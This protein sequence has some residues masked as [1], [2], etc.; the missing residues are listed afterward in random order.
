MND[1]QA[2]TVPTSSGAR[3]VARR[4]TGVPAADGAGVRLTRVIGAPEL[5]MLDP[6]LLLDVFESD[7]PDDYI[8]GFPPHPHRGF[9]TVT[10]MLAGR[11]EHRDSTGHQGVIETGGV[12]WMTAGRGIIHS[13]MPKQSD[14]LL[15]GIQ[16]WVNL[17]ARLKMTD[18]DYREFGAAAIPADTSAR[19]V[20]TRV[21]AGT[22]PGGLTG[23][24]TDV[25]TEP[26]F[27][28]ITTE[29]G[30]A[31]ELPVPEVHAVMI[32]VVHGAIRIGGG[33][34]LVDA[35]SLAVLGDGERVALA[36]GAAGGRAL[37]FAARPLQ[38][39]VAR[40]G[41]FVMNTKAELVQAFE[42]YQQGRLTWPRS[43]T[44]EYEHG[45]TG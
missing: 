12:Q 30:A 25:V 43:V 26:L 3:T 17:P 14:G 20:T 10:Y 29:P 38:E 15:R 45:T 18:P 35:R 24:V 22:T 36:G 41:P 39:P 16:L 32:Y 6:F 4:V 44:K 31:L 13:E 2:P 9:E 23:P 5:N 27:L 34:E 40:G 7:N 19:G 8:A 21:I 37:L 42:D 28:D 33:S 1:C 11:M